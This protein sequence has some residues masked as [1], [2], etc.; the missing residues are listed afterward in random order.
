MP[1]HIIIDGYN[2]IRQSASLDALDRED[3]QLGR[4][5]LL[6]QLDAYKRIKRHAITVVFDG[7]AAETGQPHRDVVGGVRIRFSRPGE[8]ADSVIKRMVSRERQKALV[9]TS[10]REI[11]NHAHNQGAATIPSPEF[12]AKITMAAYFEAKGIDESEAEQSGWVPT[13]RKKGPRRRLSKRQRRNRIK[14]E[15]L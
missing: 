3:I 10:D 14:I 2:L 4:Q 12:E 11:V 13:T 6:E 9:V 5:A 1:V 15:K 8:T 7:A